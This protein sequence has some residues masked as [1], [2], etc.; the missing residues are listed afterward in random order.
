[1]LDVSTPENRLGQ[2]ARRGWQAHRSGFW[3]P[4][5]HP[6]LERGFAYRGG[7]GLTQYIVIDADGSG[8]VYRTW[9]QD[10]TAE[11]VVAELHLHGFTFGGLWSD[12]EGH[13]LSPRS[14]WI[15]VH[16]RAQDART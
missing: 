15:G 7:I 16:A 3:R 6:V 13:P 2:A 4:G 14:G 12:L 8:S 5:P 1:V 10:F 9:F 11:G